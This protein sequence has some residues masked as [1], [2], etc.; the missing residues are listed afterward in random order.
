V[1]GD[2]REARLHGGVDAVWLG[3]AH[4]EAEDG[5]DA[6]VTN[7]YGVW[8]EERLDEDEMGVRDGAQ[9]GAPC[10][11]GAGWPGA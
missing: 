2:Q 11:A 1:G 5:F 4:G 6:A 7:R 9:R 8:P 3:F 10:G